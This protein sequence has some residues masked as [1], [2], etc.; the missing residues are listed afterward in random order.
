MANL[1][2]IRH[3]LSATWLQ[4]YLQQFVCPYNV[5]TVIKPHASHHK[6]QFPSL[7]E[8]WSTWA[9]CRAFAVVYAH[10]PMLIAHLVPHVVLKPRL[11]PVG[12]KR[13]GIWL[14]S[15]EYLHATG[16]GGNVPVSNYSIP[17]FLCLRSVPSK[18]RASHH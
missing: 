15:I 2:V 4:R 17:E 11:H 1:L 8:V 3:T 12:C 13:G 14:A 18:W 10:F 5:D 9:L 16:D 7:S 6:P